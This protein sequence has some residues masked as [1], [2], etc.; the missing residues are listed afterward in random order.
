M[1][2]WLL[3]P[4][5]L[6]LLLRLVMV[7]IVLLRRRPSSQ[8]M[9]WILVIVGLPII[10]TVLYL[11]VGEIKLGSARIRR[12]REIMDRIEASPPFVAADHSALAPTLPRDLQQIATLGEAVSEVDALGGNTLG[13]LGDS[14]LWLDGLI[15]DIDS[16]EFH[17]HLLFYIYLGDHTG[18]RVGDALM[19]AAARGVQC[20]LL[21][22]AVGSKNFLRSALCR[23]MQQAGVRIVA[24]LGVKALRML[25]TR[26]DL[27]NHRKIVVIDGSIGYTGSYNIADPAFAIKAKFAPWVD[28]MVRVQGPVV[29]D[30]Q[31]L[32][33]EDWYL[34]TD[35][36]LE[37][38]LN[39]QPLAMAD[40]VAAQVIGTGP[41]SFNEALRQ[42][43]QSA[44]HTAQEE[45]I[46]T[47]PYFVPDEAMLTALSAAARRGVATTLVLPERND[48]PLV[49]ATSRSHYQ[50]LLDA[51]VRIFQ[52]RK[53]L[54]HAKT[55]TIDRRLA[56]VTTANLDRR[57]F[58]LNFEVSLIVYDDD[59]ASQL[60]FLQT[61]YLQ[62]SRSV[63]LAEWRR[64][65]VPA[66]LCDSAASLLSPLL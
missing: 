60:R 34:D 49:A 37:E 8:T 45:L 40:G 25:F 18:A 56:I 48:S 4:F 6:E 1:P 66:R 29:W 55:M 50:Y 32:F 14:D 3:L 33:V 47:T 20:R 26:M 2:V 54:L 17:C 57:S 12:H 58:E 43:L 62:D 5:A 51:G 52:Y 10:G 65:S 9:A 21:L 41:N 11:M 16:A 27:R 24:A 22:D 64:R 44:M 31:M 61:T 63:P 46:L 23:T 35:E 36:S 13:L 15:G 38:L 53:G 19:R 28:C 39:I 7:G 42:L 30:L 59:F